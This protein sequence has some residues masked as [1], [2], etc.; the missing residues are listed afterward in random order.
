MKGGDKA[1]ES[2]VAAPVGTGEPA[3][4]FFD[5]GG[6]NLASTSPADRIPLVGKAGGKASYF[7]LPPMVRVP[8]FFSSVVSGVGSSQLR[9]PVVPRYRDRALAIGGMNWLAYSDDELLR[10]A[11]ED[12]KL[13]SL[14]CGFTRDLPAAAANYVAPEGEYLDLSL[15]G[16]RGVR[17]RIGLMRAE[18]VA[19]WEHVQGLGL[20]PGDD[21]VMRYMNGL[22]LGRYGRVLTDRGV[23]FASERCLDGRQGGLLYPVWGSLP[24][25]DRLLG[26]ELSRRFWE[27]VELKVHGL[28]VASFARKLVPVIG[29]WLRRMGRIYPPVLLRPKDSEDGVSKGL[30]GMEV[31]DLAGVHRRVCALLQACLDLHFGGS[32]FG[33]RTTPSSGVDEVI[34][35]G[36]VQIFGRSET[37]VVSGISRKCLQYLPSSFAAQLVAWGEAARG[38]FTE[39][40]LLKDATDTGRLSPESVVFFERLGWE[41]NGGVL[42]F[43][44]QPGWSE[45]EVSRL[46][47]L[48]DDSTRVALL[49]KGC[50]MGAN[51]MEKVVAGYMEAQRLR[52]RFSVEAQPDGVFGMRPGLVGDAA[53]FWDQAEAHAAAELVRSAAKG[54]VEL[55]KPRPLDW[56]AVGSHRSFV[57]RFDAPGFEAAMTGYYTP[58]FSPP[59]RTFSWFRLLGDQW[60]RGVVIL[61]GAMRAYLRAT[62]FSFKGPEGQVSFWGE[63][64]VGEGGGRLPPQ[65][66]AW[67]W[68]ILREAYLAA[69]VWAWGQLLYGGWS[70]MDRSSVCLFRKVL[71][72]YSSTFGAVARGSDTPFWQGVPLLVKGDER[73]NRYVGVRRLGLGFDQHLMEF[74]S[75][76]EEPD[77]LGF[78]YGGKRFLL[79]TKG[80]GTFRVIP[81]A[82]V[83]DQVERMGFFHQAAQ[84][85]W[86][87]DVTEGAALGSGMVGVKDATMGRAAQMVGLW[88]MAGQNRYTSLVF[89]QELAKWVQSRRLSTRGLPAW[90]P[91]GLLG[92][93][94]WAATPGPGALFSSGVPV[95]LESAEAFKSW[96]GLAQVPDF[97]EWAGL[98]S[99]GIVKAWAATEQAPMSFPLWPVSV[100]TESPPNCYF[101]SFFWFDRTLRAVGRG[102]DPTL[103]L[104]LEQTRYAGMMEGEARD[105]KRWREVVWKPLLGSAGMGRSVAWG[106]SQEAVLP[107]GGL[108]P[109][110]ES[111]WRDWMK[112]WLLPAGI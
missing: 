107:E 90:A 82:G 2:K 27:L 91:F 110:V 79:P 59:D 52:T 30:P 11:L 73:G 70:P 108:S 89:G 93:K 24:P 40:G 35:G 71:A 5:W 3:L 38:A 81:V 39:L 48:L 111:L 101:S 85:E 4:D 6:L 23:T 31:S 12:E 43:D 32:L 62:G 65:V 80:R 92:L 25:A 97:K 83:P 22:L 41:V 50:Q 36:E 98:G 64:G 10:V 112:P 57:D 72:S 17:K 56:G 60:A 8:S 77:S 44:L 68:L 66:P 104:P 45:R 96:N 46:I 53:R 84:G 61:E 33:V 20:L 29:V 69:Y 51:F 63:L 109:A 105:L 87:V 76:N 26:L 28:S 21:L 74:I 58:S 9:F 95:E 34:G 7:L 94:E 75:T 18:W 88:F 100:T 106:G 47:G 14:V 19:G 54:L 42:R 13:F 102:L 1:P 15:Y 103:C 99:E 16:W 37:V 78:S 86:Y 67:R 55:G 49:R